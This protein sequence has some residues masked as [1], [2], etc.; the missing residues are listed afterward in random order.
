MSERDDD[1]LWSGRGPAPDD[2]GRLEKLLGA[3]RLRTP[4]GRPR[5]RMW[6][7]LS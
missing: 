7:G 2:V 6:G 4:L 1:Y 3:D 5:R